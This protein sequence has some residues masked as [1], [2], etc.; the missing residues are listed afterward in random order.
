ME[1][2]RNEAERFPHPTLGTVF[3]RH[4]GGG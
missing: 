4:N 3:D 2:S 1:W